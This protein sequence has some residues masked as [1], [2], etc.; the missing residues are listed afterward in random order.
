[1]D[2]DVARMAVLGDQ[3]RRAIYLHVAS[4]PHEVGR[5][6]AARAAGVSRKL[7]AFH[8]ERLLEAGLLEASYRRLSGRSGPGAG[9]PAKLYRPSG[10]LEVSLPER[11]YELLADVLVQARPEPEAVRRAARE[12]GLAIGHG[13]RGRAG[14]LRRLADHGFHPEAGG[15]VVR[16]RNC[17]FDRLAKANPSLVCE[18][19]L[20]LIT[21]VHEATGATGLRP[22]LDPAPGRCCV[23]LRN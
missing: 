11:R 18:L 19:N 14:M 1:V 3:V 5:D 23:V 7:A 17:P 9:R 20:A 13:A 10:Q 22:E 2:T 16:L 12:R 8:L 21:G 15:R 6:E 4:S